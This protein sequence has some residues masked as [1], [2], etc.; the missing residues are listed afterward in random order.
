MNEFLCFSR[1][2]CTGVEQLD[3]HAI[4]SYC[5][6]QDTLTEAF[7]EI[8]VRL[9]DLEIV[10]IQ[11]DVLR[12]EEKINSV[13]IESLQ[14]VVGVH[15]GPGMRKIIGGLLGASPWGEKLA[16]MVEECCHG[17]ILAFTKE[18]MKDAPKDEKEAIEFYAGMVRRNSRVFNRCAAYAPG[19]ALVE[20]IVPNG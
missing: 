5:R 20:G 13:E 2:R 16:F 14:K 11:G 3:E 9:P 6:L 15:V 12:C 17:I 18:T 8:T 7:I 10:G 19:S 4:R 1:N